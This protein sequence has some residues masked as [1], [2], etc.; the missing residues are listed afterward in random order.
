[1]SLSGIS[2]SA[3]N[4]SIEEIQDQR[5]IQQ[6]YQQLDQDLQSGNVAAAQKDFMTLEQLTPNSSSASWAQSN[7]AIAQGFQRLSENLRSG[8]LSGAQQAYGELHQEF[9]KAGVGN[10]SDSA[11]QSA[12]GPNNGIA[13][14]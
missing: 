7:D 14:I 2:G 1:M 11:G 12:S 6:E 13:S 10:S 4:Y 8:N 9:Q 3:L 5:K